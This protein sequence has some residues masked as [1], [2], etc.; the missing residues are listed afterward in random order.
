MDADTAATNALSTQ[1]WA[2]QRW[3][4]AAAAAV[5]LADDDIASAWEPRVREALAARGIAI[6]GV[7]REKPGK[8]TPARLELQVADPP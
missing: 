6:A 4:A 2:L 3:R 8:D 5:I 1:A 7:R